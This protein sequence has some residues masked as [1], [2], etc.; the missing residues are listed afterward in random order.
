[1]LA[2][3]KV[4]YSPSI[5]NLLPY[6][7]YIWYILRTTSTETSKGKI[8]KGENIMSGNYKRVYRSRSNRVIAGVCAGLGEYLNIDPTL[9]RLLFVIGAILGFGSAFII[10]IVLMIV[11][12]E[13]PLGGPI[14][15]VTPEMPK[16]EE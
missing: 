5:C 8:R 16:E 2:C 12:P 11:V 1:M 3:S 4:K 14:E 6:P 9:V 13:E 10:Y 15:V 7:A